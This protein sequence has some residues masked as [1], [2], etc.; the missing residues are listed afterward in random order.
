MTRAR[1]E[2]ERD[3]AKAQAA[4]Q[5]KAEEV[6][7]PR[8]ILTDGAIVRREWLHDS[9]VKDNDNLDGHQMCSIG[10]KVMMTDEEFDAHRAAGVCMVNEDERDAA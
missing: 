4:E 10:D 9:V 3:T 6:R 5:Q 8:V 2:A 7:K 1:A